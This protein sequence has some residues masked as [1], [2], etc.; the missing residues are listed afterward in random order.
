[1]RP[2]MEGPQLSPRRQFTL[3]GWLSFMLAVGVYSSMVSSFRTLLERDL[4][5]KNVWPVFATIPTAWCALWWLYRRW[6]LP[7]AQRVHTIGPL[8]AKWILTIGVPAS[9][10]VAIIYAFRWPPPSFSEALQVALGIAVA[11]VAFLF[12]ACAVSAAVSLPAATVMLLYLMLR[13]AA[14][15]VG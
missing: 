5:P 12:Y 2:P 13:P 6:R 3:A 10:C 4:G 7:Q 8:I 14:D 15:E 11:W 9:I 1:M